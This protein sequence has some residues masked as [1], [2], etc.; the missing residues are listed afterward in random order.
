MHWRVYVDMMHLW[1]FWNCVQSCQGTVGVKLS[2]TKFIDLSGQVYSYRF[3]HS[4][5]FCFICPSIYLSIYLSIC[6]SIYISISLFVCMS[7]YLSIYL[8]IY[9]PACLP[10]YLS[11]CLSL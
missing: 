5:G 2:Y 11:V 9:L 3:M 10:T 7:V 1:G 8:S 6:L 4:F